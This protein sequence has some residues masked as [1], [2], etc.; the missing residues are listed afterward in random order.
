VCVLVF[1]LV[2]GPRGQ[3]RPASPSPLPSFPPPSTSG[4]TAMGIKRKREHPHTQ[5]QQQRG[6][7]FQLCPL[8]PPRTDPA[9][10]A[11]SRHA[12]ADDAEDD[13]S[14]DA[15]AVGHDEEEEDLGFVRTS[16]TIA[17]SDEV[18]DNLQP[19][20]DPGRLS[21]GRRDGGG[22]QSRE[23]PA[24]DD[25]VFIRSMKAKKGGS[26]GFQTMGLSKHVLKAVLKKG[27]KVPTPIQRRCIP[28]IMEGH[29]VVGMA[30][31]GSG[32]TAAFLVPLIEK[33][34]S[35]SAKVCAG[36]S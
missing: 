2:F 35:H 16:R 28:L 30:R 12:Q 17:E 5:Q 26:G 1:V 13:L 33:L 32:K 15:G 10:A 18:E 14:E 7:S 6:P 27:Y 20:K 11:T 31:T 4:N 3:P 19:E 23:Q 9:L 8:R 22:D 21:R 25:D 36:S 29:D 34:A 24:E